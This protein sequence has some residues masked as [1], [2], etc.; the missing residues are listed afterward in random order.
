VNLW[1]VIAG[2]Y[3]LALLGAS[4]YGLNQAI[5]C[6]IFWYHRRRPVTDARPTDYEPTVTIQL[7]LYNER[8]VAEDVIRSACEV[9]YPKHLL[10]IQVLD[11]STDETLAHTR[12]LVAEYQARGVSIEH[13]HREDRRGFKS[14]ALAHGL[15]RARGELIAVFDADFVVPPDFLRRTVPELADPSV[16]IVQTRWAFRNV[17]RSELTRAMAL[18]LDGLF[19]VEYSARYWAG[20]FLHF[21]GTAGV[22]RAQ[23]VREAGGWEDDTLTEDLDLSFRMQLAGWRII[24]RP[25]VACE[26]EIP[27]DIGSLRTQQFRWAKGVQQTAQKILPRLW[28]SNQPLGVKCEGTVHLLGSLSFPLLV[29]LTL[30][31]PWMV[32]VT[33]AHHQA[34]VVEPIMW[35]NS[36]A[37]AGSWCCIALGAGELR[38][39]RRSRMLRFPILLVLSIGMSAHCGRATLEAVLGKQSPFER[40]PKYGMN[41]RR[42]RQAGTHDRSRVSWSVV[43]E[44]VLAGVAAT[45]VMLGLA[46]GNYAPIPFQMLLVVGYTAVAICSLGPVRPPASSAAV[47]AETLPSSGGAVSTAA[48]ASTA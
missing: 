38:G 41:G 36:L 15:A 32:L 17:G 6:L 37:V 11:D 46:L 16:G 40:T 1:W 14:G 21:N 28:R 25:D 33:A 24:Y 47:A 12:R 34:V 35:L 22:L 48:A 5:L 31:G 19:V 42:A 43:T 13:I 10:D 29:V 8:Y 27:S 20:W 3:N 2:T 4:I 39:D 45:S 23:A 30:L 7:P 26:S 9:E 18:A 44:L